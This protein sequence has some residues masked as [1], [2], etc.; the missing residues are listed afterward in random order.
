MASVKT[1]PKSRVKLPQE[2]DKLWL[3]KYALTKGLIEVVVESVGSD[4][5]VPV[6]VICAPHGYSVVYELGKDLHA[7]REEA[8]EAAKSALRKK[9]VQ[10]EKQMITLRKMTFKSKSSPP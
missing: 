2:G 7:T 5:S 4:Q 6:S 9:I 10:L 8:E 3:S 1:E